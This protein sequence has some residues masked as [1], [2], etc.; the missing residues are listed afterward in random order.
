[1]SK[2]PFATNNDSNDQHVAVSAVAAGTATTSELGG[3]DSIDNNPRYRSS[4]TLSQEGYEAGEEGS[5][6]TM[7]DARSCCS[8]KSDAALSDGGGG[9]SGVNNVGGGG[10]G[11]RGGGGAGD[12]DS[13]YYSSF[14]SSGSV[15]S[16]DSAG[17]RYNY[18]PHPSSGRNGYGY[19]SHHASHIINGETRFG[20]ASDAQRSDIATVCS[21]SVLEDIEVD[22]DSVMSQEDNI[23]QQQQQQQAKGQST[24]NDNKSGGGGAAS[25]C[26][27]NRQQ[28]SGSA[29]TSSGNRVVEFHDMGP[30][31]RREALL[32]SPILGSSQPYPKDSASQAGS[33]KSF[34][35]LDVETHSLET[36]SVHSQ[37]DAPLMNA[38]D[39]AS[40]ALNNNSEAAASSP[41]QQQHEEEL[42]EL[43]TN[44]L[45]CSDTADGGRRSPGGTIYKGRGPRRYQGRHMHLP[46]KRFHQNGVHLDSVDEQNV[47]AAAA[48]VAASGGPGLNGLRNGR[49]AAHDSFEDFQ[50]Q[51]GKRQRQWNKPRNHSHHQYRRSSRSHSRSR[52]RSRSPPAENGRHRHHHHRHHHNHHHHGNNNG[53]SNG[54]GNGNG[55][56]HRGQ[57]HHRNPSPQQQQQQQGRG[58]HCRDSPRFRDERRGREH[59]RN[60]S[61]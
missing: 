38:A 14:K 7:D 43:D 18:N 21:G 27:A 40:E 53:N 5:Q 42:E 11:S 31:I 32:A 35:S 6:Q 26:A 49:G 13:Y 3:N 56:N 9:F 10:G 19:V 23:H 57:H 59:Y 4:P 2:K 52:S 58:Y 55:H 46:L 45:L 30:P 34:G 47:A 36:R 20:Y 16:H 22:Q 25:A 44:P 8:Q 29:G 50:Q 54:N 41:Q 51:G 37:D 1:M 48:E 28:R 61:R 33:V 15:C 24:T 60:N 12:R 17:G 39:G